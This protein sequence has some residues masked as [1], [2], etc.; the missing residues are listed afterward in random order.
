V[1]WVWHSKLWVKPLSY[2]GLHSECIWILYEVHT[3]F[4]KNIPKIDTQP[5]QGSTPQERWQ[6]SLQGKWRW[7]GLGPSSYLGISSGLPLNCVPHWL[8]ISNLIC[9]PSHLFSGTFTH[10]NFHDFSC[11]CLLDCYPSTTVPSSPWVRIKFNLC[12]TL[13]I[14]WI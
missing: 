1:S 6:I 11:L 10:P 12:S 4:M 3:P 2:L 8:S 14:I 7:V 9:S 5:L 13:L